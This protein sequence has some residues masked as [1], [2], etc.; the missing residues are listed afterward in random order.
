MRSSQQELC[1]SEISKPYQ[2]GE[3]LANSNME[4]ADIL[5]SGKAWGRLILA[6]QGVGGNLFSASHC[7]GIQIYQV[8]KSKTAAGKRTS[9]ILLDYR[10]I[11]EVDLKTRG[12]TFPNYKLMAQIFLNEI[13]T[14]S[15]VFYYLLPYRAVFERGKKLSKK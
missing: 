6:F 4:Q 11:F 3:A 15:V 12:K 13:G 2:L 9:Y 1:F 8:F 10:P 7:D 5:L 14:V